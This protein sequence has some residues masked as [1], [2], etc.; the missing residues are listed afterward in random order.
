MRHFYNIDFSKWKDVI[1]RFFFPMLICFPMSMA[2]RTGWAQ[3]FNICTLPTQSQLPV[4][5]IHCIMQ[6]SEGYM[7]YGTVGGLCR[8]NGFQI[9]IFRPMQTKRR[10]EAG[11]IWCMTE[12]KNG[13]IVMGTYDGLFYIDKA[14][15]S[16]HRIS[17]GEIG[18][19]DSFVYAVTSDRRGNLW[20]GLRGCVLM[21]DNKYKIL[22][23][24]ACHLHNKPC[25]PSMIYE[26]SQGNIFALLWNKDILLLD[27]AKNKFQSIHWPLSGIPVQMME[28]K[29]NGC[30]WILAR[31]DGIVKLYLDRANKTCHTQIQPATKMSRAQSSGLYMIRDKQHDLFW[32]TTIDN[33]YAY[34]LDKDNQL[35]PFD[36]SSFLP[37]GKKIL[38]QIIEDKDG[39]IYVAGWIPHT[40]II[41]TEQSGITRRT[42][43]PIVEQTGFPLLAD[44]T[45]SDGK[46]IWIWQ[47]RKGL[48]LYNKETCKLIFSP[49]RADSTITRCDGINNPGVES[50][51]WAFHGREV[52][53]LTEQSGSIQREDIALLP[54]DEY[55]KYLWEAPQNLF[56]ATEQ[57]LYKVSKMSRKVKKVCNLPATTLQ[58]QGDRQNNVYLSLGSTGL[59]CVSAE[60]KLR[61][62][63]KAVNESFISVFV[64]TDGMVWASTFE[65]NVYKYNPTT[66]ALTKEQQ[67]CDENGNA[68]K[69]ILVDGANHVWTLTDQLVKEM[70]PG[71]HTKRLLRNTDPLIDV[72]YF[73]TM[74]RIDANTV[75]LD[76]AGA[77]VE[78]PSST[79]LNAQAQVIPHISSAQVGDKTHFMGRSNNQLCLTPDEENVELHLTT[80]E[81]K[82][83]KEFCFAYKIKGIDR[84][85][86]YL[87]QGSNIVLLK[88]IPKGEHTI[89]VKATD[90]YGCW[91]RA[92]DLLTID[93]QFHWWETWWAYV[94]YLCSACLAGWLI[95]RLERRIHLLRGLLQR[96]RQVSLSEIELKR[97]D[98]ARLQ[99]DDDFLRRAIAKTE[100]HISDTEYNVEALSADMCMSR[101]TFYHRI[102]EQTGLTPTDFIRDIRLKKAASL[103]CSNPQATVADVAS[104]VGFATPKYFSK[105]FKEKF[106]VLPKDYKGTN[107]EENPGIQDKQVEDN[108]DT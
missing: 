64:A 80:F 79:Q 72:H 59:F 11:N 103:L 3:H 21:L 31:E 105:R 46:H 25:E 61:C 83:A 73:Y 17:I 41:S 33:L 5:S 71:S 12:D 99:R 35:Q 89:Q 107:M 52:F 51:I 95:W 57:S 27:K 20:I 26:D 67:M 101:I 53:K 106:G 2:Y 32:T 48:S 15:Y 77:L 75:C 82:H 62:L 108:T 37:A 13:N 28:D 98:I 96:R 23:R 102:Q 7:W 50:G 60:G 70:L 54:Q 38:D 63:S 65:G 14:D 45:V 39:N 91:G 6:D 55:I 93:R 90:T 18:S 88:K 76:G 29:A 49:W 9:D 8:D 56:I 68:I 19:K 97:E 44:R 10:Q 66:K 94:I 16:I 74:N 47:G 104:K 42:I 84:E 34:Y 30:Y 78:V 81:Y 4:A 24:Y 69:A 58:M 40:F 87:P 100:E 86:V 22:K 36:L 92:Y 85:W 1:C 43:E